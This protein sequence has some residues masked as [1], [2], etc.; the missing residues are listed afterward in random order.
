MHVLE[1]DQKAQ[2]VQRGIQPEL[3]SDVRPVKRDLV[4][5]G[6][7]DRCT[8]T[9]KLNSQRSHTKFN[10]CTSPTQSKAGQGP[11]FHRDHFEQIVDSIIIIII[12]KIR[13]Q[14][15]KKQTQKTVG[16]TL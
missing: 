13:R 5:L 15:I 16:I 12:I 11:R 2:R 9:H 7:A 1:N 6:P 4:V 10:N 14:Y 8:P 3:Q